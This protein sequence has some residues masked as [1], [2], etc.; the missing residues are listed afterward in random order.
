MPIPL[1]TNNA[2][3]ALAVA[4]TPTDTVLQVTAG[5]GQYF[6]SPTNGNYFMLTLVQINNPEV[7]EIVQCTSRT[8]DYL[9]VIRGQEGTAPQIFNI[10]DNVQLRITA[11]SL[12]FFASEFNAQFASVL[13]FG[14]DNTGTTDS[15]TAIQAALNTGRSV[16]FP[17]GTYLTGALTFLSNTTVYGESRGGVVLTAYGSIP[18]NVLLNFS[19]L[20]NVE[21][22][23][24]S[25][26]N[27]LVSYSSLIPIS[28]NTSNNIYIHDV[29]VGTAATGI[30][31]SL[32]TNCIL[33]DIIIGNTRDNGLYSNRGQF[34]RFNKI[35][36]GSTSVYHCIQ[37]DTG[38]KNEITN[39]NVSGA[40]IFGI[41]IFNS[42]YDI[43]TG[44]YCSNTTREGINLE[45][46]NNCIISNNIINWSTPNISQDFGLS[47]FGAPPSENNNF[48]IVTGNFISNC[49]KS[50]I[51]LA[52]QC[53]FNSISNNTIQNANSLNEANAAGILVYGTGGGNNIISNN[54][55]WA[56]NGYLP[57][58]IN[59]SGVSPNRLTNNFLNDFNLAGIYNADNSADQINFPSYT[60]YVPTVTASSG[61]I[62][63]YTASGN[64]YQLGYLLFFEAQVTI[65][66]NGTGAVALLVSVPFDSSAT[67]I[68]VGK[69]TT[70]GTTLSGV[71][72]GHQVTITNTANTYPV[73]TGNTIYI[74]GFYQINN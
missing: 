57:Y 22:F 74:S 48:N 34:N 44:N 5:T 33:E 27:V 30:A 64:Y 25:I 23:N 62:T 56:N 32:C 10:S 28:I 71:I 53:Q 67:G 4:I 2:A 31:L 66:D 9:T 72:L 50:G 24:I 13:D 49:G 73:A 69:N 60:N 26:S 41:S 29:T 46:S 54:T 11:K 21:L 47:L 61:A 40:F 3:A 70:V 12:N 8:G 52:E 38:Y 7:S 35:T 20:N 15:T 51:A 42:T 65:T 68:V 37:D 6:P 14:A 16:Y 58:G 39:C 43:V 1:F 59:S 17:N 36:I 63:S 45:N 18:S 19:N 55:V